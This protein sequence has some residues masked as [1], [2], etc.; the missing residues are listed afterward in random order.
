M[1]ARL[2]PTGRQ[3][4][5]YVLL[6]LAGAAGAVLIASLWATEPGG[7]PPR[8]H[9]AFA[10]LTAVGLGWAGF[11]GWALTR[12][13]PLYAR[14]RVIAARLALGFAAGTAAGTVTIAAQRGDAT[15]VLTALAAGLVLVAA[16]ALALLHARARRTAL[17]RLRD[18]LENRRS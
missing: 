8:T 18:D 17:L 3:R 10:A 5:R 14:D 11:A 9:L 4:L 1:I 6:L 15:A 12:R 13:G 7:L 16:A 2:G